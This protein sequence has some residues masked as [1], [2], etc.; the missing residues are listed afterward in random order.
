MKFVSFNV[1]GVRACA[2]RTLFQDIIQM[3]TDVIC[4]QETKATVEQV[5]ET[6]APLQGYHVYA[7]EAQKKGYSGTAVLCRQEPI[8]VQYGINIPEHDQEGRVIT[9][10]WSN[11]YLVNVYVPNS[12]SQLKR[13]DYRKQWDIDFHAYLV[14]LEKNKP[15]IICGDMNVCHRDIDLARPKANYD[16]NPGY[17]QAEIDGMDRYVNHGFVDTFRTMNPQEVCYSWWS[18]RGGA[19]GR[20]VGWR[21]DYFLCSQSL[22]NQIQKADIYT[23]VMGS[24]HCP[25]ALEIDV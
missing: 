16:K 13:L 18:Y 20:N 24:D 7:N 25:V 1:N 4:L 22:K 2:K 6:L 12:S 23:D 8:S 5:K 14:G 15:V 3:N 10:E 19:R 17:T 9:C 21:I 11:F